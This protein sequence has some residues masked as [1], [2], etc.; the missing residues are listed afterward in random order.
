MRVY[1]L[2]VT[3]CLCHRQDHSGYAVLHHAH[4]TRARCGLGAVGGM[5]G[6]HTGCY[7]T[8]RAWYYAPVPAALGTRMPLRCELHRA[9]G[10][11]PERGPGL[12]QHNRR[13]TPHPSSPVR[14]PVHVIPIWIEYQRTAFMHLPS[15]SMMSNGTRVHAQW[16]PL[17]TLDYQFQILESRNRGLE[18]LCYAAGASL[19]VLTEPDR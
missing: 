2:A 8:Q 12:V 15:V 18:R 6:W 9:A 3:T 16:F 7:R 10:V 17:R 4:A 5:S 19:V 1:R 11:S 13:R 14:R